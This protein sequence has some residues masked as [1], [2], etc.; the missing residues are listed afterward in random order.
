MLK[1]AD[2]LAE[3]ERESSSFSNLTSNMP[4]FYV[5]ILCCHSKQILF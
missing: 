2:T 4:T 3:R 1:P 5:K